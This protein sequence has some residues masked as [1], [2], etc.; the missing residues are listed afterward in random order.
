M[1]ALNKEDLSLI[2][3]LY[4]MMY[5]SRKYEEAVKKIWEDGYITGEMHMGTGEE[6]II[7][8]VV[9]QLI[10]GDYIA[11]DHRGTSA[12]LLRSI[13]PVQLLLEF[14]GHEKGICC[15]NGGHMHLFSKEHWAASSGIV[16]AEGPAA[17][18]FAL[19]LKYKKTKNIAVAFFGEGAM[20]QGMLM[21]SL[22]LS[23]ALNLPVL[24]ICKDNN[25]AITTR[26]NEVTGGSLIDRAK[27]F[28][29]E[30]LEV[31]GLDLISMLNATHYAINKIR[32]ESKP[33]FIQAHCIHREGHFLGDPLLR[34]QKDPINE[35]KN[36]LGPLIKAMFAK[37]G[38]KIPSR[39]KN[40]IKTISLIIKSGSQL[41]KKSDPM[42]L[43]LK[44]LRELTN[45]EDLFKKIEEKVDNE[46]DQIVKKVF[47]IYGGRK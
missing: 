8:S 37:K 4:E 44:D 17:C 18:G 35:F 47:E 43:I 3:K 11:V 40:M 5:K 38:T 6:A 12:F 23:S 32:N 19:A 24:F 28:K 9:S 10:D 46:I 27:S 14:M 39:I 13:D 29:I 30:S 22:N 7:V 42:N 26:S 34:F 31:D 41:K 45:E 15:G 1:N 25:W 16:G 2:L 21:E 33:F 36:A 20:N